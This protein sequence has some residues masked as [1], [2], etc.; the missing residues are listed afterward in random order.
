MG[1][2]KQDMRLPDGRTMI[3]HVHAALKVICSKVLIVGA[4]EALSDCPRV[5]DRH[6]GQGPLAGIEAVL[7]TGCDRQYVICPCD[8]PLIHQAV[9]K[10]LLSKSDAM[11]TVFGLPGATSSFEPLPMRLA[12]DA[13]TV[14][15]SQLQHG[16]RS[17]H[18]LV[19]SV[20][21]EVVE[22][23]V[24]EKRSL[25]NM[26]TIEDYRRVMNTL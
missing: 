1:Q 4:C 26:N 19:K 11:A 21:Y 17:V 10:R 24:N 15:R 5:A 13:L 16:R 8:V 25:M 12:D 18:A 14:V 20:S 9:L 7:A 22:V 2:P 3:E 23:D 6:P